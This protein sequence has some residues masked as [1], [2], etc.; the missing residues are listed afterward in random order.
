[1]EENFFFRGMTGKICVGAALV[2]PFIETR[3]E[4]FK[5]YYARFMYALDIILLREYNKKCDSTR[6]YLNYDDFF[7]FFAERKFGRTD[8]KGAYEIS[9]VFF[10]LIGKSKNRERSSIIH[11][12]ISQ[13]ARIKW[14]RYL[15]ELKTSFFCER[16]KKF[17]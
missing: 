14:K 5:I 3:A 15:M 2:F 17:P 1:M 4:N 9:R 10:A 12:V 7:F 6:E 8:V 13:I 16:A 11:G